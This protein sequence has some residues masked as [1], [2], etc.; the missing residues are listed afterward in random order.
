M[1]LD[2]LTLAGAKAKGKRPY[3]FDNADT[4]RVLNIVMT[5]AQETAVLRERLDTIERL[6]EAK[7]VVN[8]SDIDAFAPDKAAA[9]ERGLMMQ[10]F[11]A[12]ILRITQQDREAIAT[13]EKSSEEVADELAKT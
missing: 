13:D 2:P 8:R 7:G 11:I 4:E 9:A 10:E 1:A 3:F 6:L 5:L 12:R